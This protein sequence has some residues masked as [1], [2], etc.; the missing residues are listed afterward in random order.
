MP[1][2]RS[3][4]LA[5]LDQCC[6]TRPAPTWG[7][8]DR[9]M[10]MAF[11]RQAGRQA[12]SSLV[13][14]RDS[15]RGRNPADLPD[16]ILLRAWHGVREDLG[17]GNAAARLVE[18][19]TRRSMAGMLELTGC[20]AVQPGDEAR[21]MSRDI[22]QAG[23]QEQG[24]PHEETSVRWWPGFGSREC[25]VRM[26]TAAVARVQR[27]PVPPIR[28][29]LEPPVNADFGATRSAAPDSHV[30]GPRG[31]CAITARDS[32]RAAPIHSIVFDT[33]DI[34]DIFGVVMAEAGP[35]TLD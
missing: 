2:R 21:G 12:R 22:P 25:G 20:A 23:T 24:S 30:L 27:R 16:L 29:A 35:P 1:S 18:A 26:S 10:R 3:A 32:T 8:R 9:R 28:A 15:A 34:R 17:T 4:S 13:A 11:P 33:P 14:G 6:P 19:A 7:R 31:R 5:L